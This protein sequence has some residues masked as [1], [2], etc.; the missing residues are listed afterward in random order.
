MHRIA[1]L[2]VLV[3]LALPTA[4]QAQSSHWDPTTRV[5]D[6]AW[7]YLAEGPLAPFPDLP[8][9]DLSPLLP[10]SCVPEAM[11]H[12]EW[13]VVVLRGEGFGLAIDY[14]GVVIAYWTC[15]GCLEQAGLE[16]FV[17]ARH[18]THTC[19]RV[20]ASEGPAPSLDQV[21]TATREFM[22]QRLAEAPPA[23]VWVEEV[24][25]FVCCRS[26]GAGYRVILDATT[27]TPTAISRPRRPDPVDPA[28]SV[29]VAADRA[30]AAL[31]RGSGRRVGR[32]G[33]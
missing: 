5:L 12:F 2:V 20:V 22:R 14:G 10:M 1:P 19:S 18:P 32:T 21:Q 11:P 28:A 4:A 16:R 26:R 29:H 6:S 31:I 15:E 23:E 33:R 8:R 9:E 30:A 7:R 24:Q 13:E 27:L 3:L 25:G 17:L